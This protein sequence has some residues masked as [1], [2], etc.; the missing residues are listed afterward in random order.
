MW[1]VW[2]AVQGSERK[3]IVFFDKALMNDFYSVILM[4]IPVV[5]IWTCE[6]LA[7]KKYIIFKITLP[8]FS[9]RYEFVQ[10]SSI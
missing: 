4:M 2:N 5:T 9:D 1:Q 8:W 6:I 7:G 3:W 10:T